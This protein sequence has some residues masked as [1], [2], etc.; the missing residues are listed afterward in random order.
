MRFLF[1][2]LALTVPT[3]G[4][5]EDKF[6]RAWTFEKVTTDGKSSA[7][8]SPSASYVAQV[9]ADCFCDTKLIVTCHD[10]KPLAKI[11]YFDRHDRP[12]GEEI[13]YFVNEYVDK[14]SIHRLPLSFET[15]V[16]PPLPWES[17]IRFKI[18]VNLESDDL[19][20]K[21]MSGNKIRFLY[22]TTHLER[23]AIDFS[24]NGSSAAINEAIAHCGTS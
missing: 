17:S 9:N 22:T 18:A 21:L 4:F 11:Q 13:S 19:I 16:F 3:F 14:T 15:V 24:L 8:G 12:W 7:E 5:A 23:H 1:I 10:N 20:P 6:D 2:L